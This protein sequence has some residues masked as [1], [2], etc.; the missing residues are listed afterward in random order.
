MFITHLHVY[1]RELEPSLEF[2]LKGLKGK[3]LCRRLMM[4]TPGAEIQFDGF[5]IYLKEIGTDWVDP[6]PGAKITGYHHL[7]F[8]VE[9]LDASMKE[10][11]AMPGVRLEAEPTVVKA[12]NRRCAFF[13]GPGN[14]YFELVEDLK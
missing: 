9:D 6:E 10:L 12:R 7:G 1:C 3:L 4:G 5:I 13:Y 11:L 8:D 2:M 14:L